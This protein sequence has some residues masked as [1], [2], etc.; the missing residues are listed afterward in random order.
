M[1]LV[2]FR[3]RQ[4]S[5]SPI[6]ITPEPTKKDGESDADFK[7]RWDAWR[8]EWRVDQVAFGGMSAA[9]LARSLTIRRASLRDS[10][11]GVRASLR[12]L[13]GTAEGGGGVSKKRTR[14]HP[15]AVEHHYQAQRREY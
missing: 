12:D 15:R 8:N 9:A 7:K 11:N 13:G 4:Q 5:L 10:E 2:P 1:V 3:Q 6:V 14:G